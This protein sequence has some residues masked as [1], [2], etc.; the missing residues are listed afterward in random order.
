MKTLKKKYLSIILLIFRC[1]MQSTYQESG[2]Y[3]FEGGVWP[4]EGE[5]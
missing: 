5:N 2:W 1:D 4:L 3:V